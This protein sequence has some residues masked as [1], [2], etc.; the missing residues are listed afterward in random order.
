MIDLLLNRKSKN[1]ALY[2]RLSYLVKQIACAIEKGRID[3][4]DK[5]AV[6]IYRLSE[7]E[8]REKFRACLIWAYFENGISKLPPE[9]KIYLIQHLPVYLKSHCSMMVE[10][11][12]TSRIMIQ[13]MVTDSAIHLDGE[14]G[15]PGNRQGFEELFHRLIKKRHFEAAFLAFDSILE[16]SCESRKPYQVAH[17][18]EKSLFPIMSDREVAAYLVKNQN[19]ICKAI[20]NGF[21]LYNLESAPKVKM[22]EA[23]RLY[24]IG[25]KQL[26]KAIFYSTTNYPA[27]PEDISILVRASKLFAE[28]PRSKS[29]APSALSAFDRKSFVEAKKPMMYYAYHFLNTD[30]DALP[31]SPKDTP[32]PD[33]LN[34]KLSS[35]LFLSGLRDAIDASPEAL[36]RIHVLV[37]RLETLATNESVKAELARILPPDILASHPSL[38]RSLI[39]HELSI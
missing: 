7:T 20:S 29:L 24:E 38:R 4:A 37:K 12:T 23:L 31:F 11:S 15:S 32:G 6:E 30:C 25:A 18:I 22:E 9:T 5:S 36:S 8:G 10:C 1:D 35:P 13:K 14:S 33:Y 21:S 3:K 19:T 16:F 2:K 27:Y 34:I 17:L 28:M 26:S 39:T